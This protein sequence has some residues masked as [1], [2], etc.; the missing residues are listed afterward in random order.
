[1]VSQEFLSDDVVWI[2]PTDLCQDGL[3]VERARLWAGAG[4]EMM[5]YASGCCKATLTERTC[6]IGAAMDAALQVL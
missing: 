4:F 1:M 6:N 3:T 5:G 2:T